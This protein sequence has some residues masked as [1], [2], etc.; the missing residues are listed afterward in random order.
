[1]SLAGGGPVAHAV[2]SVDSGGASARSRP[3]PP[4]RARQ[5]RATL[6]LARIEASLLMRSLLVLGGLLAGAGVVWAVTQHVR[7]VWWN[8]SWRL[9][10]G[11][12]VLSVTV[13]VAAH[14]AAGRAWRDDLHDLYASF[15]SPAGT[16]TRA[17]LLAAL[18]GLPA[19]LLLIAAAVAA[20]ELRGAIGTPSRAVLVG[21]L[22]L[23]LAGAVIGVAVG[24]RFPH[25]L[26]GVL[27][28]LVWF[29]A[30]SQTN[31]FNGALAWLFPWS[32]ETLGGLPGPL[33]GYPP[34][35]AHDVELAGIAA[36][37]AAVALVVTARGRLQRTGLVAACAVA[38][39]VAC[40]AGVV[41]L[42]PVP[43]SALDHLAEEVAAPGSV[44]HCTTADGVYYCVYPGFGSL[45]PE[46]RGP[47]SG[48]LAHL[49]ARPA[50]PLTVRQVASVAFDDPTLTY[51]HSKQQINGWVI[52]TRTTLNTPAADAVYP[53]VGTWPA[54]RA[55][56]T[57]RFDLA[58]GAAEWAV[59][60][61][62][63]TGNQPGPVSRQCVP[64]DQAREAIAIW[65]AIL[66]AHPSIASLQDGLPVRGGPASYALVG[67]SV[68]ATWV[69]PGEY[70][71]YFA[72]PGP[73]PTAD[74]YL[75]AHAM[76]ALPVQ[77]VQQVLDLGWSQWLDPHT[78]EAALAAALGISPPTFPV[79]PLIAGRPPPG[80]P[81][82]ACTP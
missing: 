74:G 7:P 29:G 67:D 21:G 70:V 50:Q 79:P 2:G 44:Q 34:A 46:L 54:G 40:L 56:D 14:L 19:S 55:Q 15:P 62:P 36:L 78:S 73:Q 52:Q 4:M 28:A 17:Q 22:L 61:P 1:V 37:A 49:P 10:Y 3:T 80:P 38:L 82:P 39:A 48:V 53:V 60:L 25:P 58:L 33:S 65:L 27:A 72:S 81:Q 47:V 9:G 45:L 68:V 23:V 13:L 42:R 20:F 57:A 64:V 41:Q 77:N 30:F 51:G 12:M 32:F 11:Q 6:A 18:G 26:A 66:A 75:L 59:G 71:E 63:T 5:L 76:T 35:A 24:V 16:R 69:Y 8:A 31:R 43:T